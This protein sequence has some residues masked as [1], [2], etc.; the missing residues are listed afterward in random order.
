[1]RGRCAQHNGLPEMF[2]ETCHMQEFVP[3]TITKIGFLIV[4]ITFIVTI[5][6]FSTLPET[7]P[8]HFT[9]GDPDAWSSKWSAFGIMSFFVIPLVSLIM[10]L[11]FYYGG[12]GM[13]RYVEAVKPSPYG[14]DHLYIELL[15]PMIAVIMLVG[16][17]FIIRLM[18]ANI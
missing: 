1:M 8:T 4:L 16:Q 10:C 13:L 18:L 6:V 2:I 7:I 5:Y 15:V 14:Y 3:K 17:I 11:S 9:S 12:P